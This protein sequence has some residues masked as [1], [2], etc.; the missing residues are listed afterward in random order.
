MQTS[1]NRHGGAKKEAGLAA[2]FAGVAFIGFAIDA[3]VL[4]AGIAFGLEP[5]IARVVS[6]FC[7]MQATFAINGSLVFRCL[8]RANLARHWAGYMT[9][10][11]VGNFCNYWIFVTLV[12]LHWRFV[13]N[14]FVALSAGSI[15]AWLVNYAGARLIVFR[16]GGGAN[17]DHLPP[18]EPTEAPSAAL[19]APP[20]I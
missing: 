15:F 6:L 8:T 13:S 2:K 12:S 14:N 20:R 10:S 1:P 4:H 11:G 16:R 5:A 18:E 19:P 9:T 3:G 7:A 17:A